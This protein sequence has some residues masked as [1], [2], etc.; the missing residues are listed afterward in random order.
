MQTAQKI[1]KN[2]KFLGRIK[3]LRIPTFQINAADNANI[4][5][6][7]VAET[8][9]SVLPKGNWPNSPNIRE[10]NAAI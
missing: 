2:I 8:E 10:K 4:S 7:S 5:N 6:I 9:K 1:I 3:L